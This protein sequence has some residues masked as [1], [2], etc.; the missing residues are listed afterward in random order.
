M[1]RIRVAMLAAASAL[2]SVVATEVHGVAVGIMAGCA[3][4]TAGAVAWSSSMGDSKK[5]SSSARGNPKKRDSIDM[6]MSKKSG[7]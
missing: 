7:L 4:V 2:A 1:S 3:A 5:W 6:Y